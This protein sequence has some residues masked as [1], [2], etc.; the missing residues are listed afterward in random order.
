VLAVQPCRDCRSVATGDIRG[1]GGGAGVSGEA[2]RPPAAHGRR[3]FRAARAAAG[4]DSATVRMCMGA[5]PADHRVALLSRSCMHVHRRSPA[6]A[7]M[8]H[9]DADPLPTLH[10]YLTSRM[11][12]AVQHSAPQACGCLHTLAV[13]LLR[14]IDVAACML[15]RWLP[16]C[17]CGRLHGTSVHARY[18]PKLTLCTVSLPLF[19]RYADSGER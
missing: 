5:R 12:G 15:M 16:A 3:P 14:W 9:S 1:R 13:T 19:P 17:S 6:S 18:S 11:S 7:R 8:C 2:C 4:R 10:G